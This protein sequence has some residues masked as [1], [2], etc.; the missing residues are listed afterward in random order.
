MYAIIEK[1][2]ACAIVDHAPSCRSCD[3]RLFTPCVK[4]STARP[5]TAIFLVIATIFFVIPTTA[6]RCAMLVFCFF[7]FLL[8][9]V[10]FSLMRS[11]Y[12]CT[13]PKC[14]AAVPKL[15]KPSRMARA[16]SNRSLSSDESSESLIPKCECDCRCKVM[17][18][19]IDCCLSHMYRFTN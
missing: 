10:F 13:F 12:C 1:F 2:V 16:S 5:T 18:P 4:C 19:I 14:F 8:L 6:T 17:I 9:L 3:N 7:L 11:S 15:F